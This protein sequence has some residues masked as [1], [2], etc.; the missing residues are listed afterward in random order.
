MLVGGRR[1]VE[2]FIM[3]ETELD[4]APQLIKGVAPHMSASVRSGNA[5]VWKVEEGCVGDR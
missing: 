1:G 5:R 2:P 4:A 3:R